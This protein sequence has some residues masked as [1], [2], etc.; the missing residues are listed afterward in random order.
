MAQKLVNREDIMKDLI[1]NV[2]PR[3][4]PD[5]ALDQNRTG[6]YGYLTESEAKSIEDTITLEQ[7]RA[8][9][10]CPELSN[11][12]IRV[13][14]TAK[15]RD[16]NIS[17]ATPG[18]A[19]AIIG[20][21][22]ED[23]LSRGEK[24]NNE[25]RFVIDR[26]SSIVHDKIPFSLEDDII[27]RAVRRPSGYVYAASYSGEHSSYESYIQMYEQ[28]NDQGQEMITMLIQIYQFSYNIQEKAV[29]DA[30]GFLY[31]GIEFDYDNLLAGFEVYYRRTAN[32]EYKMLDTT[33]YLST[34]STNAIYYNDDDA[35]ILY[36]LN[37]PI[38]GISVNS[39]I[40][41]E[42]RETLGTEG[43]IVLGSESTTF[44]LYRDENYNYA[45]INILI[46][47]ISDTVSATNGDTMADIKA[48]LIDAKTRRDN[49]TTEH[50]IISYINNVDAN[51]QIIKKR[52]DIEDRRMYLYTHSY[53]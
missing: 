2:T 32:E 28:I 40:R 47:L 51:V 53:G 10:Y 6:I 13:R 38:L 44:S 24:I 48:K 45:G 27:I 25:I 50:D 26:R 12:E 39:M 41:V 36:I 22:K 14:Q 19:F 23:I 29:T 3:Y 34:G 1:E 4:F 31:D 18:K 52:N 8:Q 35:N 42:A 37:N 43:M 49:I 5:V 46:S 33:H 7:R 9:D 16:I 20:V 15:I 30:V 11:S 21:L 17:R